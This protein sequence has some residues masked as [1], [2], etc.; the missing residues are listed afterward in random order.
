[1]SRGEKIKGALV[2]VETRRSELLPFHL[3]DQRFAVPLPASVR[4]ERAVAIT[5]LP[6][7]PDIVMGII[8]FHGQI[9]PV[10]NIRSRFNMTLGH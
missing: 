8:N 2:A 9:I 10:V 6:K 4:V 5:P 7:A 3:D 1:M